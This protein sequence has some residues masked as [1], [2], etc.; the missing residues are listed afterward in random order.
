[1]A[2]KRIRK[3]PTVARQYELS[4]AHIENN[5]A[6]VEPGGL[7]DKPSEGLAPDNRP[8]INR[9]KETSKNDEK[10]SSGFYLGL[11]AIDQAIF[12]YFEN[13]IKPSVLSNGDLVDVPVIYG[14]GERWKLAQR[15]G[16]YRD[17]GG[18]VQAPLVMIKRESVEKRR[19][20]GNKLDANN[21]QL[22]VTYQ[23]KFTKR[24]KYD[25]FSL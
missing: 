2:N 10:S 1:M 15:D 24:N 23:E 17:K 11:E 5:S 12:F 7:P 4:Q 14:S 20:L 13:I 8:H 16:F 6:D 19:D 21:P 9:A 18:K 3:K 25:N 22:Y